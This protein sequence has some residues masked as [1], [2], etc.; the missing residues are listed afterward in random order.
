MLLVGALFVGCSSEEDEPTP[1]PPPAAAENNQE[2]ATPPEDTTEENVPEE[3][4]GLEH[5]YLTYMSVGSD[6]G[7][8]SAPIIAAMNE[9]LND[10]INAT[11]IMT[12]VE[13]EAYNITLVGLSGVDSIFTANFHDFHSNAA[14][15]A[16]AEIPR[17]L[18][19]RYM[20]VW[21][22]NNAARLVATSVG[23]RIYAIPNANPGFSFPGVVLRRDWFPEGMTTVRN[24]DDL[25]EFLSYVRD[26]RPEVMPVGLGSGDVTWLPGAWAF[27]YAGIMA[28]GTPNCTFPSVMQK[29]DYPNFVLG[30]NWA[31]P[32]LM[33]FWERMQDWNRAGFVGVDNINVPTSIWENFING[34]SAVGLGD[35]LATIELKYAGLRA[36]FPDAQLYVYYFGEDHGR[37]MD[38]ASALNWSTGIPRNGQNMERT[39]MML[40][41]I[42]TEPYL[43]R[44]YTYGI[45]GEDH[46]FNE[47]GEVII[48]DRENLSGFWRFP[49]TNPAFSFVPEG[50][51]WG[52]R[53]AL[54][55]RLEPLMFSSPF[56]DFGMDF[57]EVADVQA[58]TWNVHVDHAVAIYL[59][60]VDD[61]QAALDAF[62]A[63]YD[64]IGYQRFEDELYAQ[65][66]QFII[67]MGLDVTLTR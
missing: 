45:Y 56:I 48:F 44:L 33:P 8:R 63:D 60:L 19:Q 25:Y 22:A 27:G 53:A 52:G 31:Y 50:G 57:T 26:T 12:S 14:A 58:N 54:L 13:H 40:E 24:M 61:I 16:F 46:E 11:L 5:V 15:G 4:T 3:E 51:H 30:P 38:S 18:I 32:G 67:D 17:E 41:L 42:Y 43:H 47:L 36:N 23:G 49:Q 65:M 28:P 35:S 6:P 10:R 20:P 29:H 62:L 66:Q 21:Y 9:Y 7:T 37:F 59:G 34:T 1:T 64:M 2:E 55:E 39:L